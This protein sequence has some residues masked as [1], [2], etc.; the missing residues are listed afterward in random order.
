M[1]VSIAKTKEQIAATPDDAL[2]IFE[3]QTVESRGTL[4]RSIE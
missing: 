2:V 4:T 3:S 1:F